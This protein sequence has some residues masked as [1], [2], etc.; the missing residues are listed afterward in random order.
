MISRAAMILRQKE[1]AFLKLLLFLPLI[2]SAFTKRTNG[3]SYT[4]EWGKKVWKQ[5]KLPMKML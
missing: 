2:H 3:I 5:L 4:K 1:T